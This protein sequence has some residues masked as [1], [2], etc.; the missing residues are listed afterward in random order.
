MP[1]HL[2]LYVRS[3]SA[4]HAL[5][6]GAKILATCGFVAATL[7]LPA[8][9]GASGGVLALMLVLTAASAR[10]PA[11]VLA[12]RT[13]ALLGVIGTPFLL[14]Q[15]GGE[16]TRVAGQSFALKSLLITGAFLVLMATTRVVGMLE[17]M[18]AIPG[19]A[20]VVPLTEFIVRGVDL[21]MEEVIRSDRA[22]TLRAPAAPLRVRVSGLVHAAASLLG[23]A[24]ARSDRVAAAMVLRGFTGRFPPAERRPVPAAH[25]IVGAL[26]GTVALGAAGLARWL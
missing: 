4:V 21:V 12:R 8:R 9:P 19:P 5:H 13:L 17:T 25:I 10:I 22:A 2:D 15:F 7:L 26:F 24:A 1:H 11:G 6:P 16:A 14:S 23:R 18:S 3:K 20:A